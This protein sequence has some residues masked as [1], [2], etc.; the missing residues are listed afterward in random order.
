MTATA[1]AGGR[2]A[3]PQQPQ[4]QVQQPQQQVQQPQQQV[5]RLQRPP[6]VGDLAGRPVA[7]AATADAPGATAGE[8][9]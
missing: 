5:Q 7:T 6:R 2:A 8:R 4:Q 9:S 3:R 1:A